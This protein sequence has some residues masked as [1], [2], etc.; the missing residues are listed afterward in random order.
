MKLNTS[1]WQILSISLPIMIGSAAQNII[2]L[3]DNV[4][5]Y[6]YG[7]VN[8]YDFGAI[9]LVG[10]FYL[11][12]ASIGYGFSR[13]GQIIIARRYGES[14]YDGLRKSFH[15]LFAFEFIL[16]LIL[17]LLLQF[18]SPYLF[19]LFVE[20]EE[21]YQRCLEYIYPRSYGIFFSY[22]GVSLIALYT[23]IARTKF[24]LIDTIVLVLTNVILN[25]ILIFGFGE[26]EPM[27]IRGAGLASTIAEVIAFIVFVGYVIIDQR[28][29]AI[30]IFQFTKID[31]SII[32]Q[33]YD[34]S[35]P[36]V[37][38]SIFGL[39]SWFLFFALIEQYMGAESL[40]ASNLVR[41]VYLLLSIPCWGFSAG[42]NTLVSNFIGQQKRQAVLP[43]IKRTA[44][45][46]ILITLAFAIPVALW[47]EVLLYPIFGKE[48]MSMI[49]HAHDTLI[50]LVPIMIIFGCGSIM[51]NGMMGIGVTKKVMYIQLAATCV[52]MLFAYLSIVVFSSST[53]VA[54]S[55]ELVYWGF[56]LLL[57]YIY[58][59]KKSWY[60]FSV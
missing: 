4:F 51:M 8:S 2:V 7:G 36:I 27:G 57:C 24:I 46:N 49:A 33:V 28:K 9:A 29:R 22:L 18:G 37:I 50:M 40:D 1:Y 43:I 14:D 47:P 20:S 45:L 59:H 55:V 48:D 19:D 21:Y 31:L 32:R 11:V 34:R 53:A 3:C 15:S 56:I 16:A 6:H 52:Y 13:G 10:V 12:I 30:N 60:S 42:I 41:N 44:F 58:I 25:Y 23:G 26:I 35:M 38:Q 54:W 39:G 17:F 5:L